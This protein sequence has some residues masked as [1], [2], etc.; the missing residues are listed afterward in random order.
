MAPK[1]SSMPRPLRGR[2]QRVPLGYQAAES[3]SKACGSSHYPPALADIKKEAEEKGMILDRQFS[4]WIYP[5][6]TKLHQIEVPGGRWVF[7][8]CHHTRDRCTS[9]GHAP[10]H[11]GCLVVA[12]DGACLTNRKKSGELESRASIGIFF[13]TGNLNNLSTML[14]AEKNTEQVAELQACITAL[15][16]VLI[17][18]KCQVP[19]P[20]DRECYPLHSLIIKS[21]S[22]YL[23]KGVTEW[24]PKWKMRGWKNCKGQAVANE[25]LWH[26]IDQQVKE[27]ESSV[28]VQFWLVPPAL[29]ETANAMAWSALLENA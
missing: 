15:D 7:L 22:E 12:V 1:S 25:Q 29:N 6:N 14:T 16:K 5:K 18:W 26:Q 4:P 27:L 11:R 3:P 20:D 9:C 2:K 24:L 17:L 10:Y 21:D 23:V 19:R 13:G 8:A 28:W